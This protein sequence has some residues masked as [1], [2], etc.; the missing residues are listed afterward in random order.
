VQHRGVGY[1][2]AVARN[3]RIAITADRRERVDATAAQLPTHAWRR[4]QCGPGSKGPRYYEW[5]RIAISEP[6]SRCYSLLVRHASDGEPAC[7][8]ISSTS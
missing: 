5:T 8:T 6:S 4:Y 7:Y 2:L 1:V 3:H